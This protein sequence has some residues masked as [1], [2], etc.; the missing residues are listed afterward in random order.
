VR[1]KASGE[2]SRKNCSLGVNRDRKEATPLAPAPSPSVF[3][4]GLPLQG[5]ASSQGQSCTNNRGRGIRCEGCGLLAIAIR[6][7]ALLNLI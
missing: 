4:P 3:C 1:S 7:Q 2:S 5:Q 6:P